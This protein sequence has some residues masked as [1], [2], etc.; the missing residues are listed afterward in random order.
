[1]TTAT[2]QYSI[3]TTR[4]KTELIG[5]RVVLRR[6][7]H[8]CKFGR[9]A[10]ALI[11]GQMFGIHLAGYYHANRPVTVDFS[12]REFA[13]VCNSKPLPIREED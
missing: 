7:Y 4:A 13:V 12:R 6:R 8:G 3:T 10:E 5:C 2:S 1:M 11:G 9:I